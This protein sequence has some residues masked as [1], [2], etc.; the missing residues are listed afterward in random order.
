MSR[1]QENT[2]KQRKLSGGGSVGAPDGL[3]NVLKTLSQSVDKA[4]MPALG[5]YVAQALSSDPA[6]KNIP[7]SE[8]A[9]IAL[10]HAS[11]G[12]S[13]Y[14]RSP[15]GS[16]AAEFKK[17]AGAPSPEASKEYQD[18][19]NLINRDKLMADGLMEKAIPGFLASSQAALVADQAKIAAAENI[20]P[21]S[22]PTDAPKGQPVV[23]PAMVKKEE[24]AAMEKVAALEASAI[25]AGVLSAHSPEVTAFQEGKKQS[26]IDRKAAAREKL[27]GSL[28]RPP[29]NQAESLA[30]IAELSQRSQNTERNT[31]LSELEKARAAAAKKAK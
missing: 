6:F 30:V 8:V 16:M 7:V 24:G 20:P 19:Q 10:A 18:L 11:D 27:Y 22:Q 9:R 13:W 23:T 25:K 1:V 21:G 14:S 5:E 2:E 29:V 26:F 15:V 17:V 3:S 31:L 28:G 4:A 12:Q